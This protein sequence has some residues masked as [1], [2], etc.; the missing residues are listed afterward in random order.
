MY[1]LHRIMITE[2]CWPTSRHVEKHQCARYSRC[3]MLGLVRRRFCQDPVNW[4]KSCLNTTY[5]DCTKGYFYFSF[6]IWIGLLLG[7]FEIYCTALQ[8]LLE[9]YFTYHL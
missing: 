6:V 9:T 4:K 3:S 5:D 2:D 8:S 1:S 7:S